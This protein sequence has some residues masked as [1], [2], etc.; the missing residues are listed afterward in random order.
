MNKINVGLFVNDL[1]KDKELVSKI[2]NEIE[3]KRGDVLDFS[4]F[5]N[6][7]GK[8]SNQIKC[9]FFNSSNLTDFSGHL[10]CYNLDATL[11]AQS[12]VNDIKLY[13]LCDELSIS[14]YFNL[15]NKDSKI[16]YIVMDDEQN[17]NFYRVTG[18]HAEVYNDNILDIIRNINNE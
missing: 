2:Y 18:R 8:I 13:V 6:R 1:D 4:I 7:I 15:K 10:I 12:V 17:K 5:F 11:M 3:S 9:G 16:T 14:N